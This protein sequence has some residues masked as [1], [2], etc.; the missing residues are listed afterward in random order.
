[1]KKVAAAKA[2]VL[3]YTLASF[4]L[5]LRPRFFSRASSHRLR[6]SERSRGAPTE[7]RVEPTRL[8]DRKAFSSRGEDTLLHLNFH[9]GLLLRSA[10][11]SRFF[12]SAPPKR[13]K[14]RRTEPKRKEPKQRAAVK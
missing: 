11:R 8:N 10:F 2:S 5:V 9:F 13:K 14:P 1:M 7:R 6:R 3:Q 12:A 4:A